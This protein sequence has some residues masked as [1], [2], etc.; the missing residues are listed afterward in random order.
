MNLSEYPTPITDAAEKSPFQHAVGCPPPNY[1]SVESGIVRD[2]ECRLTIAREALEIISRMTI[3]HL[4][5]YPDGP[6]IDRSDM[7][8]VLTA[9]EL[10]KPKL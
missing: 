8:E 6:C 10:T 1:M 5:P 3:S 9:L 7:E 4:Y 2:L